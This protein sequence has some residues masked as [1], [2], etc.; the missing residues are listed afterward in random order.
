MKIALVGHSQ[1]PKIFR[2]KEPD[3]EVKIFRAPGAKAVQFNG[4]TRLNRVLEYKHDLTFLWIGSNDL[5]TGVNTAEIS[6]QIKSIAKRIQDACG[7]KVI[8]VTPENRSCDRIK[9]EE[10]KVPQTEYDRMRKA[11]RK[12]LRG[13]KRFLSTDLGTT[14]W[15]LAADG[16]HL[17]SQSKATVNQKLSILIKQHK[18]GTRGPRY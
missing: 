13:D 5:R 10:H 9:R 14:C 12:S 17:S 3:V 2:P 15:K 18:D 11:V 4:D 6:L 16:I 8:L 1:I 7:S